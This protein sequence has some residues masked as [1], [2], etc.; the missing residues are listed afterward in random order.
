MIFQHDI[1]VAPDAAKI[2]EVE[3]V[4]QNLGE[5]GMFFLR[6]RWNFRRGNFIF[7]SPVAP[8]ATMSSM[9]MV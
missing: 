2:A 8:S 3:A 7:V 5:F 4:A 6:V 1:G 9:F